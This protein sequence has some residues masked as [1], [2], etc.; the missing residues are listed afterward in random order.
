MIT[1]A[2][3]RPQNKKAG[4]GMRT[5]TSARGNKY[6]VGV[7]IQPSPIKIVED[8]AELEELREFSQFEVRSFEN[9]AALEKWIE[10]DV[11]ARVRQGHQVVKPVIEKVKAPKRSAQQILDDDDEDDDDTAASQQANSGRQP[12]TEQKKQA[13]DEDEERA[14]L[15]AE[16]EAMEE[17]HAEA[18]EKGR[19]DSTIEKWEARLADAKAALAE[20]DAQKQDGE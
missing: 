3:L 4:Y 17:K 11:A 15:L 5:Y 14:E 6:T 8:P 12:K 10:D 1:V 9:E 16:V 18:I 2:R 7:G 13:E 20:Y 19:T